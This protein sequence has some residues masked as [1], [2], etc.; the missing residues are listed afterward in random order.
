MSDKQDVDKQPTLEVDLRLY[1]YPREYRGTTTDPR[2][3]QDYYLLGPI[4]EGNEIDDGKKYVAIGEFGKTYAL[5]KKG[6]KLLDSKVGHVLCRNDD[7][8]RVRFVDG[9][10]KLLHPFD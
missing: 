7:C 6:T 3:K 1:D 4:L 9:K 5:P 8:E 2:T 10:F